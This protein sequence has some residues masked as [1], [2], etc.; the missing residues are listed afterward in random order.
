VTDPSTDP[1]TLYMW[2][3]DRTQGRWP[4]QVSA[5]RSHSMISG[6]SH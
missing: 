1:S 6:Q 3:L 4:V 5:G 2:L